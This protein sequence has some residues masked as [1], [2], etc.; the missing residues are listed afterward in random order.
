MSLTI[1]FDTAKLQNAIN[2]FV[3]E[4]KA[5]SR[6]LLKEEMR[7]LLRDVM[8]FS[9]PQA[10][11]PMSDGQ[12]LKKA[13]ADVSNDIFRS[14]VP[15]DA[16]KITNPRISKLIRKKDIDGLNALARRMKRGPIAGR[17]FVT[18]EALRGLHKKDRNAFGRVK[19]DR[20]RMTWGAGFRAYVKTIQARIG[21]LQS[22]WGRAARAVGLPMKNWVARHGQ[23]DGGY[24]APQINNLRI[25][26]TNRSSKYPGYQR[27][28]DFAIAARAR[29]LAAELKAIVAGRGSR[30]ASLAGTKAGQAANK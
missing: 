28:V 16:S 30:R 22:G 27:I 20:K 12:K 11:K 25:E 1:V 23:S 29:S 15:L 4:L 18:P 26:A 19:Y 5:D 17:V 6:L 7:L 24:V 2:A 3:Y 14:A 10:Y 9:P 21:Y 13:R 8:K